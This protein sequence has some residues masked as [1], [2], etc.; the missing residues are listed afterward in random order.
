VGDP[1]AIG[2]SAAVSLRL[3]S[4][5]FT[6]RGMLNPSSINRNLQRLKAE[7]H[8]SASALIFAHEFNVNEFPTMR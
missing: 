3:F 8:A 5:N 2:L 4:E 7:S 6:R 1:K